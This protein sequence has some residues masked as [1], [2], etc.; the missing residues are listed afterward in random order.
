M[1]AMRCVGNCNIPH[2][3]QDANASI[4]SY[5][6]NIKWILFCSKETLIG[7]RKDWLIYHLMVDVL[8]HYWY[9]VQCK[10]FGYV[11]NKKQEGIV[12]SVVLRAR[13]IPDCNVL[14]Y[15]NG[16]DIVFIVSMNHRPKVWTIHAPNSEWLQCDYFHAQ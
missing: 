10:I 15:L 11:R 1:V 13:D 4:E 8:T 5:H 14:I 3:S 6:A 9:D 12:A 16:E 7:C 2:A